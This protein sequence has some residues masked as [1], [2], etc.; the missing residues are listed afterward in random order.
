MSKKQQVIMELLRHCQQNGDMTF[1]N[2]LVKEV[3]QKIG[4]GNPFDATKID[5]KSKLPQ[6]LIENDYFLIHLGGGY[7][8]FVKGI[9]TGF[10]HLETINPDEVIEKP[11]QPSLLNQVDTSE[12]TVLSVVN[13]QRI[14]HDFLY[15]GQVE[16]VNSYGSRRTKIRPE[17]WI[18]D[19]YVQNKKVQIEI[20]YT[21]EYQGVVTAFEGKNGIRH[22]FAIYQLFFPFLYYLELKIQKGISITAINCCYVL[23]TSVHSGIIKL[24]NYTFDD[25]QRMDSIRLLKKRE[26]HLIQR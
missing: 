21:T 8:Q 17:Y 7:H 20:D 22:D 19:T 16:G 10:H 26:Y 11:Y 1:H 25:V 3:A 13:N 4:F 2:N 23:R 14:L 9:D 18:G 12:S 6:I 15:D 24:Y 5:N